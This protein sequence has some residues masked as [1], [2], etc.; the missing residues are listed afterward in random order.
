MNIAAQLISG[1]W[2][3]LVVFALGM[4]LPLSASAAKKSA[5][6]IVAEEYW[7]SKGGVKLWVY[8]KQLNDGVKRKPL[9]YLTHDSSY[10]GNTMFDLTV[11]NRADYSFMDQFTQLGFD[12]WTWDHEGYGHFDRTQSTSDIQSGVEDPVAATG[13]VH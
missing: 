9:L 10:S 4:A 6:K 13:L 1:G 3:T 12:V 8:R 2:L 7:T 5:N 11:P